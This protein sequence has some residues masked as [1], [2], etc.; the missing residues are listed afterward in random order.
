[1]S[2]PAGCPSFAPALFAKLDRD[3]CSDPRLSPDDRGDLLKPSAT[4]VVLHVHQF[5][6]RPMEVMG[7]NGYLLAEQV[8]GVA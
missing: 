5:R 1:M 3:R 7:D 2:P 6:V 8:E 4:F